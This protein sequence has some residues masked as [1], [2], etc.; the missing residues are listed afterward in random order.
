MIGKQLVCKFAISF[1]AYVRTS[2]LSAIMACGRTG[3]C[4]C[5]PQSVACNNGLYEVPMFPPDTKSLIL[6]DG[7]LTSIDSS[8]FVENL[9]IIDLSNNRLS[10]IPLPVAP[11]SSLTQAFFEVC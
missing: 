9:T 11:L 5:T 6:S 7:F 10:S 2:N 3:L 8:V 4:L 1:Q